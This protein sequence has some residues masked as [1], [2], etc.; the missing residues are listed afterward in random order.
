M[1]HSGS[2][3][4]DSPNFRPSEQSMDF[5][6]T[7]LFTSMTGFTVNFAIDSLIFSPHALCQCVGKSSVRPLTSKQNAHF[8]SQSKI[9]NT[10]DIRQFLVTTRLPISTLNYTRLRPTCHIIY[11]ECKAAIKREVLSSKNIRALLDMRDR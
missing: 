11:K 1:F 2:A 5:I 6:S 7:Q 9:N 8:D 10:I 3:I 4:I